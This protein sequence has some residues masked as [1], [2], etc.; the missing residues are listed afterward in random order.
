MGKIVVV[1]SVIIT[2][3][4]LLNG[5]VSSARTTEDFAKSVIGHLIHTWREG[6][7]VDVDTKSFCNITNSF[8]QNSHANCIQTSN[9]TRTSIW[10]NRSQQIKT[11][12]HF[13]TKKLA[14]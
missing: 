10:P 3:Y 12:G 14:A 7:A 11:Q 2:P 5:S 1:A 4:P 6:N 13:S 8:A 9:F